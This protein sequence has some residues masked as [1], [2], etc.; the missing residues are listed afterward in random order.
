MPPRKSFANGKTDAERTEAR[1][2]YRR[3]PQWAGCGVLFGE[4]GLFATR[5]RAARRYRGNGGYRGNSP[6]IPLPHGHSRSG[7]ASAAA[8]ERD[9]SGQARS[10]SDQT[11][12]ANSDT[13]S[14]REALAHLRRSAAD[15]LRI[16]TGLAA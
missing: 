14:G 16:K 7:S 13:S 6:R 15:G 5:A 1:R 12:H 8:C 4:S 2:H 11:R 3:G 10:G 9:A